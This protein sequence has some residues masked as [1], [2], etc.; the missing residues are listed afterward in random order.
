MSCLV[1][2]SKKDLLPGKEVACHVLSF[3]TFHTMW[4]FADIYYQAQGLYAMTFPFMTCNVPSLHIMWF[5]F[6]SCLAIS[7]YALSCHIRTCKVMIKWLDWLLNITRTKGCMPCHIKSFFDMP[8][9]IMTWN[10]ISC[11]VRLCYDMVQRLVTDIL[12]G[13]GCK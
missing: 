3:K 11:H 7:L 13:F 10:V 12:Y 6:M 1:M 4:P 8:F 9:P 2:S 5:L